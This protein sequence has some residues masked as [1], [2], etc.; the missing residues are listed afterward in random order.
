MNNILSTTL[1]SLLS[2]ISISTFGQTTVSAQKS[3]F[4]IRVGVNAAFISD[5]DK[6]Y[7]PKAPLFPA[8]N[9]GFIFDFKLN[10]GLQLES[11]LCFTQKGDLYN[12]YTGINWERTDTKII[13]NAVELPIVFKVLAGPDGSGPF[14]FKA[15]ANLAYLPGQVGIVTKKTLNTKKGFRENIND[16]YVQR[17]EP[18]MD[19]GMGLDFLKSGVDVDLNFVRGIVDIFPVDPYHR[20]S[21]TGTLTLSIIFRVA[22]LRKTKSEGSGN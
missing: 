14:Y 15:G 13:V 1:F 16:G 19:L 2:F 10:A 20:K 22:G 11:G 7:N 8:L 5:N 21:L 6:E 17:V 4:G 18:G 3:S 9:A 12:Y